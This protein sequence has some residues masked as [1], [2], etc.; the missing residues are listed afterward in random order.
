VNTE[1]DEPQRDGNKPQEASTNP[2][3]EPDYGAPLPAYHFFPYKV[4][5]AT[6]FAGALLTIFMLAI[7]S[8][9]KS[10]F[11]L[12]ELIS[13]MGLLLFMGTYGII[14][15]IPS[16]LA[17]L[18]VYYLCSHYV[19]SAFYH[20]LICAAFTAICITVTL[21]MLGLEFSGEL[22]FF[23]FST[24][25]ANAVFHFWLKLHP[26]PADKKNPSPENT[27]EAINTR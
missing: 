10:D 9:G 7:N 3:P 1:L 4:W 13:T 24:M 16:L 11:S 8:S 23:Y 12:S 20:R 15:S 21:N 18:V 14:Y 26:R 22:K 25:A 2:V 27:G 19:K 5:F 6:N 17:Y